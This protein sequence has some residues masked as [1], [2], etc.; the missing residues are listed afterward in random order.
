M[1]VESKTEDEFCARLVMKRV[2]AWSQER[3]D[4]V[5]KWLREH[6]SELVL[7]GESYNDKGDFVARIYP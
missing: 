3:R 4:A 2:G 1:P 7:H 5:A 6:A